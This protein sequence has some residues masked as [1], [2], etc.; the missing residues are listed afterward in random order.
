MIRDPFA[1]PYAPKFI[2]DKDKEKKVPDARE[3]LRFETTAV[4]AY[5]EKN[6]REAEQK[7][8]ARERNKK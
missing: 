1:D 7:K 4:N 5:I 6:K 8:L 3:K 2:N